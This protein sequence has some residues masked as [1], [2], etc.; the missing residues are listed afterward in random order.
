MDRYPMI[1]F[2]LF[3]TL[4]YQKFQIFQTRWLVI[5]HMMMSFYFKNPSSSIFSWNSGSPEE[6]FSALF[7]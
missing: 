1:S 3:E 5:V 4:L 2:L 6:P 7:L